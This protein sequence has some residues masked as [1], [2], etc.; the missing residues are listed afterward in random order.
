MRLLWLSDA[1]ADRDAIF[2]HIAADNPAA[3]IA[4]DTAIAH[5]VERLV[6]FQIG[7]AHV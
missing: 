5:H 3:A 7:R 2:D 6:P 1:I 4:T